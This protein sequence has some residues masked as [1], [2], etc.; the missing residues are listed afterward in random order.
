MW[1]SLSSFSVLSKSILI[2]IPKSVLIVF[3]PVI[4]VELRPIISTICDTFTSTTVSPIR[5][6]SFVNAEM[7]AK[8]VEFPATTPAFTVA[9]IGSELVS[10]RDNA[11]LT[12]PSNSIAPLLKLALA[13]TADD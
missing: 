8:P 7:V 11:R 6:P 5:I 9:T 13:M 4:A 3:R 12:S 2:F 10:V 1:M